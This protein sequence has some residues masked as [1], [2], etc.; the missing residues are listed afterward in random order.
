MHFAWA[1]LGWFGRLRRNRPYAEGIENIYKRPSFPMWTGFLWAPK[2]N[3]KKPVPL[4]A[5]KAEME[6]AHAWMH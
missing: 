4:A 3:P 2:Y 1:T 6:S 5:L